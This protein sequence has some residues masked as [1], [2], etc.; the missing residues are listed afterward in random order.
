MKGKYVETVEAYL[1]EL[2]ELSKLPTAETKKGW[3]S[4]LKGYAQEKNYK[5]GWAAVNFRE[6]FKHWPG[7]GWDF[8]AV[9]TPS[10][11]VKAWIKHKQFQWA[12]RN[13]K[14]EFNRAYENKEI[15]S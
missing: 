10:V 3:Y 5:P 8:I 7:R 1:Q 13:R 14:M 4:E 2:S 9:T 11:E 12:Y 15:V 6:K